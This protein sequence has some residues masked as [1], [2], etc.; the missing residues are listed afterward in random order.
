M[1]A[2][3]DRMEIDK[4]QYWYPLLT[5]IY[6]KWTMNLK[7]DF[8]L[9]SWSSDEIQSFHAKKIDI[10]EVDIIELREEKELKCVAGLWLSFRSLTFLNQT[11]SSQL[12][13]LK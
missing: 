8:V 6:E 11:I 9:I 1:E 4:F 12:M 3:F 7:V 13:A 2:E 5:I 10:C